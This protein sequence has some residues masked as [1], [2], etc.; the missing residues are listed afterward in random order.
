MNGSVY[1][2]YF[3][4]INKDDG[5]YIHL[6]PPQD[7]GK[8]VDIKNIIDTLNNK[9]I[10]SFD[11]KQIQD[12]IDLGTDTEIKVSE[13]QTKNVN[14]SIDINISQDKLVGYI[15]FYPP[16]G[17]GKILNIDDILNILNN[18]GIKFGIVNNLQEIIRDKTYFKDYKIAEGL[19]VKQGNNGEIEFLFNTEKDIKPHMN[20]DG[21]VDYH[22]LNLITNV[23]KGQE[24]AK[25]IPEINGE[26]GMTIL[27]KDIQPIKVKPARLI[28]GR[29]VKVSQD[30]STILAD[31]D[32]QV[33]LED[34]KLSVY[35][36]LEIPG[37]VD[38]STGDIEF[39]GTVRVKGNVLTG[40]SI[41]AKGDIE[42]S[43]VVEGATLVSEG[44]VIL[45]RGIQGM[46]RGKIQAKGD[47]IAKYIESC[48][49]NSG[50][51]I[52]TDAILHSL[53]SAKEEIIVEGKKGLIS[54]GTIR[55]AKAITAKTIGSNMGTITN[56]EV[57]TD[58]KVIDRFN[59]L[60]KELKQLTEEEHKLGQIIT[61][62]NKR[63]QTS[64]LDPQKRE[65][66]VSATRSKIFV[67]SKLSACQKEY[68]SILED[69]ENNKSG[70][71]N[72]L[73]AVYPGVR[74]TI[75]N[76]KYFVR[77]QKKYCTMYQDGAD[78]KVV[79]YS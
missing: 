35:D 4:L 45:S 13:F 76:V 31:A 60:S 19:D 36:F 34:D 62:L 37:N 24:L 47:V 33:K 53:V 69:I 21:S 72:I 68:S 51:S 32:G 23:R 74:V 22:K 50:G 2:G 79:D 8:V 5:I 15:R 6:Y 28:I 29:N 38:S 39:V 63:K 56:L 25:V 10:Y 43:G 26:P 64:D 66:L 57:G 55:S 3:S 46:E 17:N 73:S 44:D 11:K 7:G 42:V 70:K 48:Q 16:I 41:T 49:V 54:G 61:L 14:E 9:E 30:K 40:F 71:V 77:E 27:G 59:E 78:I 75:N 58:P 67:G 12:A 20:E 18:A 65:M 1:D 52:K